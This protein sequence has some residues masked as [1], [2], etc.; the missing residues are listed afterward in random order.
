MRAKESDGGRTFTEMARRAQIVQCTVEA[1]AEVGYADA[2]MAEIARRAGIAKS[3][4][5]YH[6]S[7]KEGLMGE[8]LRTALATYATFMAPR[9]AAVTSA[10]G[11]LRA[12]LTGTA[13]YVTE[14][15]ALHVAV[16]E[17]AFN[18]TAADGRPLVAT[19]PLE[20]PEPSVEDILRQGQRD[21]EFR[22]FDVAVVAGVVRAAVT[23][24]MAMRQRANPGTDLG[25]YAEELVRLFDL[26]IRR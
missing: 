21:G 13:D 12:Y 26:G 14:H 5:S 1:L 6:F 15:H 7:D 20:A 16:I 4:V 18:A 19:M 17:I 3:V 9:L 11:K 22:D 25:A 10:A 24:D 8:V 23:R 2:S